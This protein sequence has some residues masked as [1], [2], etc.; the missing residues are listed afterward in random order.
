MAALVQI[1]QLCQAAGIAVLDVIKRA[2]T[3]ASFAGPAALQPMPRSAAVIE[4]LRRF[5]GG[6]HSALL[7]QDFAGQPTRLFQAVSGLIGEAQCHRLIVGALPEM[8]DLV[9]GLLA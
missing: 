2:E 5:Q 1:E 4:L 6:H 3:P 8:A 7:E 9:E